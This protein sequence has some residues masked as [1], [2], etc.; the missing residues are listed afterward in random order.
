MKSFYPQFSTAILAISIPLTLGAA[1]PEVRGVPNFQTLNQ[2]VYRGGQPSAEG[3]RSL[4]AAGIK[5]IVDLRESGD[6]SVTE[7]KMV[8]SLG[9][10]YVAVPM[11]GMTTPGEDQVS[12][13]LKVLLDGKA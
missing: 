12:N 10:R 5:T 13:A 8:T 7:E 9:M 11:R 1:S 6:R 2:L 3:F 4:A